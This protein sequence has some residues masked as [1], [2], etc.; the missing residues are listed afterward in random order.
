MMQTIRRRWLQVALLSLRVLTLFILLLGVSVLTGISVKP[1]P[2]AGGWSFFPPVERFSIFLVAV[3]SLF[4]LDCG[5]ILLKISKI[6]LGI[7]L[8]ASIVIPLHFQ[9]S[10]TPYDCH[11][12]DCGL[13]DGILTADTFFYLSLF[14]LALWFLL[15]PG[16]QGLV[17]DNR[18]INH[19]K[20]LFYSMGASALITLLVSSYYCLISNGTEPDLIKGFLFFMPTMAAANLSSI[21]GIF[22]LVEG[23]LLL[24]IQVVLVGLLLYILA[25]QGRCRLI[26]TLVLSIFWSF[27]GDKIIR[28]LYA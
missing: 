1:V 21:A 6:P 14:W 13:L 7:A 3:L 18:S 8:A 9:L 24:L 10:V 28:I 25:V 11:G 12:Y 20:Y 19:W 22:S 4:A 17:G 23:S 2:M 27:C 26:F 16:Y 15:C 5:A